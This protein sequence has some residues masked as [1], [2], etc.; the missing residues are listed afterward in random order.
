MKRI[1]P[2]LHAWSAYSATDKLD[3]N[4]YFC[5]ST[6]GEPGTVVDPVGLQAGDLEELRAL[7]GAAAVVVLAG[8]AARVP[9]ADALAREL[10]CA[11]VAAADKKP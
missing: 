2:L 7:G 5:Q 1:T 3:H 4:A 11:V 6:A 10:G 9:H 8:D